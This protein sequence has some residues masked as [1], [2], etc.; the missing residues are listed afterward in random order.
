M[1]GG[2]K[3][4]VFGSVPWAKGYNL[5]FGR[6]F[7]RTVL[8]TSGVSK[9]T[10]TKSHDYSQLFY[11]EKRPSFLLS[12]KLFKNQIKNILTRVSRPQVDHTVII[13]G[14]IQIILYL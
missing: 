10:L 5:K 6:I 3:K 14:T 2:K 11:Q 9:K 8:V 12:S 1:L 13:Y 7:R 4:N